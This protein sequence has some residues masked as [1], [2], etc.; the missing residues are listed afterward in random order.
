MASSDT[1][2]PATPSVKGATAMVYAMGELKGVVQEM[3]HAQERQ[4]DAIEKIPAAV[5]AVV[6]PAI[7]DLRKGQASLGKRVTDLEHR[8]WLW[9][10]GGTAVLAIIGLYVGHPLK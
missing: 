3:H 7:V 5:L 2:T 9:L 1:E 6:N 8:Q 4:A 10:G